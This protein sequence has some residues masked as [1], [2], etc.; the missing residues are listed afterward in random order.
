M[1]L[2]HFGNPLL[3][4]RKLQEGRAYVERTDEVVLSLAG[5]DRA[6]WLHAL[7]SQ[8]ILNLKPGESTEALLLTPQGHIEHQLKIISEEEELLVIT[9]SARSEALIDWLTKMRFRA[10]V[11][12][13]K[14]ELRVFGVFAEVAGSSWV[15]G[16][17]LVPRASV[18]YASERA[19]FSYRELVADAPP[20][21]ERAGLMAR[22]I[23][24]DGRHG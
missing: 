7:V 24:S 19:Q 13:T 17:S 12:V 20:E 16:F 18:S 21:L 6:S 1:T 11:S 22:K 5:E 4:Q 2:E 14:T 10:K 3:E 9:D 8:D 23:L 15:D